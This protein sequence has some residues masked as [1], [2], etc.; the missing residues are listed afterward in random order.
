MVFVYGV[1]CIC[2]IGAKHTDNMMQISYNIPYAQKKNSCSVKLVYEKDTHIHAFVC[3][4]EMIFRRK[5]NVSL[6]SRFVL[7]KC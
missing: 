7:F 5:T 4:F 2:V 3:V 1:W 6:V